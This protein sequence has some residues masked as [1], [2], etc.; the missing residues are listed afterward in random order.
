MNSKIKKITKDFSYTVIANLL[1]II[2]S[3]VL[4]LIVPR[5]VN[6]VEY[7]Y[8]Q[9][10]LFYVSYISYMSFGITDGAL[11]RYGG[12]EYKV[13]PKKFSFHNFGY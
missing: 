7:G 3:T 1:S 9:L 8:W 11:L 5:F 2:I 12:Q 10:Y 4:I 13:I 6:V